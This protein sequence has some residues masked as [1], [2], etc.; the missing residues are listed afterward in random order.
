MNISK[1]QKMSKSC[2]AVRNWDRFMKIEE[3]GR[4][5]VVKTNNWFGNYL[6]INPINTVHG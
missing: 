3:S 4:F 2:Y 6:K 1:S 5:V